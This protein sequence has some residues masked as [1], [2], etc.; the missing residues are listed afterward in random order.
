[1]E[2]LGIGPLE[3]VLI[4]I[5]ALLLLG[6]RDMA[7][8]ARSLALF[9][10]KTILS[11]EA[12]DIQY[13]VRKLPYDLMREAGLEQEDIN[14][15]KGIPRDIRKDMQSVTNTL[16]QPL[17]QTFLSLNTTPGN[18]AASED[19]PVIP[20]PEEV[21]SVEMQ[22]NEPGKVEPQEQAVEPEQALPEQEHREDQ[23]G[24]SNG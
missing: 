24:E 6:P 11:P 14:A 4:L 5:I 10:R 2:F 7:K 15:L 20:T 1:M 21:I 23:D 22:P 18:E 17:D 19:S 12:R 13:K 16:N 9:L 3:L 8:A